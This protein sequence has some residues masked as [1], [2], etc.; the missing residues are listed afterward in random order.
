MKN[1]AYQHTP[2]G[3]IE[4]TENAGKLISLHFVK[5]QKHTEEPSLVLQEA[6][7]QLSDYFEGKR[8]SFNLPLHFDCSTFHKEVYSA[9]L[10]VPY[11][12][13]LS[14][15]ELAT[16]AGNPDASRAVGTAM[17]HNPFPIIVPC[18]RVLKSDGTLGN[19]TGA[20]G[21]KTKQWLLDHEKA[22]R[23]LK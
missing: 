22:I 15:K 7:W 21:L 17:A 5:F 19:Y 4:L 16:L 12:H 18:H 2:I 3:L 8:K 14:Y 13:T 23:L 6:K 11:G 20:E 10:N 1:I 9:L